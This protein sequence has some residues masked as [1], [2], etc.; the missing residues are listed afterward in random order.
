MELVTGIWH[1]LTVPKLIPNKKKMR[2]VTSSTTKK[3]IEDED[4]QFTYSEDGLWIYINPKANGALP[5]QQRIH[6][7]LKDDPAKLAR[8]R[9]SAERWVATKTASKNLRELITPT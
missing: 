7:V 8:A 5:I 4:G 9:S 3:W 6:S 2:V 1:V